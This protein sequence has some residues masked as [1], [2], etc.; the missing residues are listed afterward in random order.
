MQ[1]HMPIEC[2]TQISLLQEQTSKELPMRTCN[3]GIWTSQSHGGD[4]VCTQCNWH[5]ECSGWS[6]LDILEYYAHWQF[7]RHVHILQNTHE[8]H[9]TEYHRILH[10]FHAGVHAH[11]TH[12]HG[13]DSGLDL[14]CAAS[15]LTIHYHSGL[16]STDGSER[17]NRLCCYQQ[18]STDM[19]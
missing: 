10:F 14:R 4:G 13:Q 11:K 6:I 12:V 2:N 3:S 18:Q 5:I 1:E 8:S 16:V 7:T 15:V 19:H 17:Q 9:V